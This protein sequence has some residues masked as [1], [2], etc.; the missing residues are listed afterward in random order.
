MIGIVVSAIVNVVAL[1][2]LPLFVYALVQRVRHRRT[3]GESARRAGLAAGDRRSLAIGGALALVG[4]LALA[5]F[6]P[7]LDVMVREGSPQKAFAGVGLWTALPMALVYGFVKTGIP[8]EILFRGL[9]GGSLARRLPAVWANVGQALVFLIPHLLVL[10][11]MPELWPLLFV[12]FFGALL[13]GWLRIRSGSVVA[14]CLVH[15]AL[16]V[17]TCLSVAARTAA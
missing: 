3:F 11:V 4:V 2:A 14:P 16:N 13:V 15:G 9:I 17:A 6:P 8:E 5:L 1:A 10:R 12:V 7:P